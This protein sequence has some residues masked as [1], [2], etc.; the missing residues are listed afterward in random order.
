MELAT[1]SCNSDHLREIRMR[2]S[3]V[4]CFSF[5]SY[6]ASIDSNAEKLFSTVRDAFPS[7]TCVLPIQT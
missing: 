2:L 4:S 6:S 3:A 7:S 5:A 1:F